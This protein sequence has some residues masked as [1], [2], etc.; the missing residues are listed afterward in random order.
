MVSRLMDSRH[1]GG[2]CVVICVVVFFDRL[3]T[4]TK[5]GAY[6]I[7]LSADPLGEATAD[8][9]LRNGLV[10]SRRVRMREEHVPT[11]ER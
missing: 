3:E 6:H 8:E 2:Q 5:P 9:Q 1:E 4:N 10:E 7:P 11:L